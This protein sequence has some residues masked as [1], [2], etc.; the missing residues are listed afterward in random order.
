MKL[1]G[2][3]I[4]EKQQLTKARKEMGHVEKNDAEYR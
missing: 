1:S 4:C 2:S 3:I